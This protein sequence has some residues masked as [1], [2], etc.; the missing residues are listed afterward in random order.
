MNV[1]MVNGKSVPMTAGD[2]AE[3]TA[4][5]AAE[6]TRAPKPAP[7]LRHLIAALMAKG[8]ITEEEIEAEIESPKQTGRKS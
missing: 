2:I 8:V 1:K 7:Q 3:R 5:E 4:L 6:R